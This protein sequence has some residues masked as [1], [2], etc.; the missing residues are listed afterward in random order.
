[1]PELLPLDDGLPDLAN[2]W[3][4]YLYDIEDARALCEKHSESA[5]VHNKGTAFQLY[6]LFPA[7]AEVADFIRDGVKKLPTWEESTFAGL[8]L[9]KWEK[10]KNQILQ[11]MAKHQELLPVVTQGISWGGDPILIH[12]YK[13]E[14]DPILKVELISPAYLTCAPELPIQTVAKLLSCHEF[15]VP[16]GIEDALPPYTRHETEF[17]TIW[18]YLSLTM[19]EGL[20]ASRCLPTNRV[21]SL[22]VPVGGTLPQPVCGEPECHPWA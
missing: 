13:F 16:D 2:A 15:L 12:A 19:P 14:P 10:L 7:T 11:R 4:D 3:V 9:G 5:A 17:L 20:Y 21:A 8:D 18:E 22:P 6:R 1:M